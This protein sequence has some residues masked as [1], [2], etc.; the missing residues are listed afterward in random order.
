MA[1]VRITVRVADT[2]TSSGLRKFKCVQNIVVPPTSFGSSTCKP[3]AFKFAAEDIP[4]YIPG[5]AYDLTILGI[6]RSALYVN[7]AKYRYRRSEA[8]FGNRLREPGLKYGETTPQQI[9]E[10]I[11]SLGVHDL[12]LEFY[13][14]HGLHTCMTITELY[15]MFGEVPE[16]YLEEIARM[17]NTAST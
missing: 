6:L 1:E 3:D 10:A 16:V 14:V 15:T 2:A 5:S 8:H 4:N 13:I 11:A 9:L 12:S 17:A 7:Y